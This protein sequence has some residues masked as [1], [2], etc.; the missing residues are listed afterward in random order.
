MTAVLERLRAAAVVAVLRAPDADGALRAVDALVAGGVTGIEVTY[1]TPDAPKVIRELAQRYG[2][3][4]VLGAGTVRTPAEATDAVAAGAR[5]LV[6]PGT[7]DEL[8]AAMLGTGATV[9]LGAL[10]PS[11]VMRGLRAGRAR[12]EDLPRHA[13]RPGLP[14]GA[15]G[16]VPGPGVRAR[17]GA[18][19]RTTLRRVAGRGRCSRRG[20]RRAVPGPRDIA[21]ATSPHHRPRRPVRRGR[22]RLD[23]RMTGSKMG[24]VGVSTGG[25]SIRRCSRGG[26]TPSGCRPAP[27]SGTTSR[28]APPPPVYREVVAAIARRPAALGRAGDHAQD[29]PARRGRRP[30]RRAATTWPR[31]S[32]RSP[33]I[34]KRGDRLTRRRQGPG[35]RPARR[36]RSSCRPTTS[37]APA[38]RRWSSGPAGPGRALRHQLGVRADRPE[39]DHLHRALTDDRLDH[40]ARRCTSAPA[41]AR[42]GPLRGD[43]AAPTTPTRC[44]RRCRRRAWS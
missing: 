6:S 10:T 7:T 29:G 39:Q 11:E 41:S 38:A 16:A 34:A 21:A 4:I 13:R 17:P 9:L 14:A 25:S 2:E 33:A 18:S 20:R 19:T 35:D 27:W 44:W 23:E 5:Y 28:W 1:S 3:Q 40:A 36:W 22:G 31:R 42:P 15:A 26:P 12:G 30:V 37:P 32:A 24:F 8:A 43:R